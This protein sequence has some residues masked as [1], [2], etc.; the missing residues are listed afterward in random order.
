MPRN[1]Q[2][3]LPN[4]SLTDRELQVLAYQTTALTEANISRELDMS[5]RMLQR[6]VS[7]INRKL[8]TDP[9]AALGD[10]PAGDYSWPFA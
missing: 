2:P 5:P 6:H 10:S 1:A 7:A 4:S 9:G 8:T 3:V